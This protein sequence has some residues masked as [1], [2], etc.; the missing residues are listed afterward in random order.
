MN[1]LGIM[2]VS[3]MSENLYLL[4]SFIKVK[5]FLVVTQDSNDSS[6]HCPMPA[7]AI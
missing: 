2:S 4:S 1:N 7:Q 3:E 6:S 5:S